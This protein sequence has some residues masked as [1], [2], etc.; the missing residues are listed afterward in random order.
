MVES[1]QIG[2]KDLFISS[3][4]ND[5]TLSE[6][7]INHI[8][9]QLG[10]SK[11]PVWTNI[12]FDSARIVSQQ[13]VNNFRKNTGSTPVHYKFSIPYFTKDK[14]YCVIYYESY[15]GTLCAEQSLRLYK[16]ENGKWIAIKSLFSI[17]S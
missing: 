17:V 3:A 13:Y 1:I 2:W 12:Y 5:K 16:N 4:T 14:N 9:E 10:N 6:K 8:A 7:E 11:L 15:C